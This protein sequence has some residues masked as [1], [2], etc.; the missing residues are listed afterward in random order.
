MHVHIFQTGV[1]SFHHYGESCI[2]D[3][4]SRTVTVTFKPPFSKTPALSHGFAKLDI[5]ATHAAVRITASI[6]QVTRY[7]ATMN[8]NTW[9]DS[10]IYGSS[11]RWMLVLSKAF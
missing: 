11:L 1:A 3:H 8:V 4:C 9:F 2:K 6:V 10:V 7:N 5:D